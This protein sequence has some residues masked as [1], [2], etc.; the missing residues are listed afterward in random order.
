MQGR[1]TRPR[2]RRD[3][4]LGPVGVGIG[5]AR[6]GRELWRDGERSRSQSKSEPRSNGH[7]QPPH[8]RVMDAP[9]C[10]RDRDATPPPGSLRHYPDSVAAFRSG[11]LCFS[12]RTGSNRSPCLS[13]RFSTSLASKRRMSGSERLSARSTSFHST[14]VETVGCSLARS[15]Y[16]ETVVLCSSFW[17]QSTSTLPFRRFLAIFET[18][19]SGSARSMTC[20]TACANGFVSS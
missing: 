9:P 4:C 5:H 19:R 1:V 13:T 8:G 12:F 14:G 15:E 6:R 20:A 16:T 10:E 18:I 11:S 2:R 3:P 17:L 7:V